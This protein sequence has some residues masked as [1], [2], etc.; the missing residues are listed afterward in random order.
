VWTE[1]I[2]HNFTGQNEDGAAPWAGLA[3]GSNGQ[4]Y[5]T[6]VYGGSAGLGTVFVIKPN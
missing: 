5:G 1:T 4:L 2:L 6:T 3:L